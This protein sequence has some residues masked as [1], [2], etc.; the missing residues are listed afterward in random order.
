[1]P[2]T[3]P[4]SGMAGAVQMVGVNA[5]ELGSGQNKSGPFDR[6]AIIS[7]PPTWGVSS[8]AHVVHSGFKC[9]YACLPDGHVEKRLMHTHRES[10]VISQ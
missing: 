10:L 3:R 6:A 5:D 9:D 8:S 4:P 7:R 2:F 1:M